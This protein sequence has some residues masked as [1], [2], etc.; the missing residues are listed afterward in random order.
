VFGGVGDSPSQ[1]SEEVEEQSYGV[2]KDLQYVLL[3]F[4]SV[5]S[6]FSDGTHNKI[7]LPILQL[8]RH[9][10]P[11]SSFAADQSRRNPELKHNVDR[12]FRTSKISTVS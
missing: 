12:V 6:L 1:T 8:R 2:K 10:R 11:S 9:P 7:L 5:Y 3:T 4:P